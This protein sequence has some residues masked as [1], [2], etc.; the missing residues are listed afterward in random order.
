MCLGIPG[1]VLE[2]HDDAGL[3]MATVGFGGVRREVCLDYTPGAKVGTYVIVHVGFAITEVDEAEAR[4]TLEVL[5]AMADAV[6][7]ELGDRCPDGPE[8]GTVRPS[9]V[10]DRPIGPRHAKRDSESV[11]R[12][13]K[14]TR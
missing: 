12:L 14:G 2:V 13:T 4:R 6:E 7:T 9:L 3:R 8:P 5:R 11:N 10:P 1:R